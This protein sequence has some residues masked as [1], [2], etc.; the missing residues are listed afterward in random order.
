MLFLYIAVSQVSAEWLIIMVKKEN[1][2]NQWVKTLKLMCKM[3]WVNCNG[4]M[5]ASPELITLMLVF[6]SVYTAYTLTIIAR[7]CVG[8]ELAIIISYPTSASRIIVLLKTP[9]K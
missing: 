9:P 6:L 5:A 8:Y 1:F 4:L 2:T 7:P 3:E